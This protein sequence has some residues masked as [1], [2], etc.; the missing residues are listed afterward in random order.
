[1]FA[2]RTV[3]VLVWCLLEEPNRVLVRRMVSAIL[4]VQARHYCCYSMSFLAFASLTDS[5]AH[6]PLSAP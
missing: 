5:S 2:G 1:M 4:I 6:S 3:A